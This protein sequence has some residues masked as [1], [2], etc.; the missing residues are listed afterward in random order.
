[1]ARPHA[2]AL[3]TGWDALLFGTN[4]GLWMTGHWPTPALDL[5][6]L[7]YFSYFFFIPAA[8]LVMYRR[9]GRGALRDLWISAG[10]TYLVCDL[11]FPWFPS[12][13]PRL[14]WPEFARPSWAQAVNLFILNRYSIGGNVF[15]SSHVAA[16]LTMALCHGRRGCWWFLPWALGIA[17]ATVSG[18]YHYGVDAAGGIAIGAVA[19]WA[20]DRL[21]AARRSPGPGPA[22]R[23]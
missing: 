21:L 22:R 12:T 11:L 10:L 18:G 5:F 9:H 1:M 7:F 20:A 19:W 3:L 14:L 4:P 23:A 6:E 15:P 2:D 8:P 13:P 17:V 16:T